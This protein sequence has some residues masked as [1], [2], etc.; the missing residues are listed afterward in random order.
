MEVP[1][2]QRADKVSVVALDYQDDWEALGRVETE[3]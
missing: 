2:V 3:G 1:P